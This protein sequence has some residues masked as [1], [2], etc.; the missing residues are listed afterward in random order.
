VPAAPAWP[1]ASTDLR[2][3]EIRAE[4]RDGC[5][6]CPAT[7]QLP[8]LSR[9]LTTEFEAGLATRQTTAVEAA[10]VY[11]RVQMWYLVDLFCTRANVLRPPDLH[12]QP[13]VTHSLVREVAIMQQIT[14]PRPTGPVHRFRQF[15]GADFLPDLYLSGKRVAMADAAFVRFRHREWMTDFHPVG[16][17]YEI[18]FHD[19]PVVARLA[20]GRV[21][22]VHNRWND[23][24][25]CPFE[26][27][28]D[29]FLITTTLGRD[30]V[31]E[32]FL[33]DPPREVFVHYGPAFTPPVGPSQDL[34]KRIDFA[35]RALKS[36]VRQT[37]MLELYHKVITSTWSELCANLPGF[38]HIYGADAATRMRFEDDLHGPIVSLTQ[39]GS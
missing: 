4:V 8:E 5:R 3:C 17:L 31:R 13:F 29:E 38:M 26:E 20:D 1:F 22:F 25:A 2:D 36:P 28:A 11:R 30:E 21:A 7:E 19:K 6:L 14:E 23:L 10:D 35:Q 9:V 34:A 32:F 33:L 16:E 12:V 39:P 37:Q 15:R 24:V 18:F 27:T